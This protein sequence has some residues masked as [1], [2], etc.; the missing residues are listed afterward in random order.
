MRGDTGPTNHGNGVTL[1]P[2][3]LGDTEVH[4]LCEQQPAEPGRREPVLRWLTAAAG[5]CTAGSGAGSGRLVRAARIADA[6]VPN[7][8][9]NLTP[10]ATV[11]EGNN[12][13]NLRWGPLSLTNPTVKGADGN[14]GGGAALGNYALSSTVLGAI[15]FIPVSDADAAGYPVTDFFG[16]ARPETAAAGF[17]DIGAVESQKAPVVTPTL[18]AIAPAQGTAGTAVSV[19]LTGQA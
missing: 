9:F 8:I 17:L 3:V 10:V 6:T 11:D 14:Y 16:N 4:R 13:I 1:N 15:D 5:G 19:T 7:P 18:S 2:G 12:W